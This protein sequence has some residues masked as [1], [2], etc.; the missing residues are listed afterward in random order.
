MPKRSLLSVLIILLAVAFSLQAVYAQETFTVKFNEV[1]STI[2]PNE[3]AV[4]ELNITNNG[5]N[6]EYFT[7][8]SP[9][10]E[11]QLSTEPTSDKNIKLYP[12][13]TYTTIVRLKPVDMPSYGIYGVMVNVRHVRLNK[14]KPTTLLV[15]VRNPLSAVYGTYL[16]ALRVSTVMPKKIDPRKDVKVK[17]NLENRNKLSIEDV[18]V[19]L[20]S[21]L[22]KKD[23]R[24]SLNPLERKTLE[25]TVSFDDLERPRK[26]LLHVT[27]E[28]NIDGRPYEFNAESFEYEIIPYGKIE[29]ET[30]ESSGFLTKEKQIILKNIGNVERKYFYHIKKPFLSW[31]YVSTNPKAT[32]VNIDGSKNFEW[33]FTISPN[34]DEKIIVNYNFWPIVIF[35]LAVAIAL[36]LYFVFRSPVVIRKSAAVTATKDGGMWRIN[37]Q[38]YLKNRSNKEVKHVIVKDKISN[39]L[40]LQQDSE[41]GTLKPYKVLKHDRKGTIASWDVGTL[42]RF[43]ERII[44][45]KTKAK[46]SILG[47]IVLPHAVVSFSRNNRTVQ[48]YSNNVLMRHK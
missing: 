3:T 26:D 14:V 2:L 17:V 25:F 15:T 41:V 40:E 24:T 48:V 1:K 45:Y 42:E 31:M 21:A 33:V 18:N 12:Y 22:I 16:P 35:L 28:V 29:D 5:P 34:M 7:V 47:E 39:L 37:V 6:I 44:T 13:Q 23:Y 38:I 32:V 11:W 30:L 4:F 20:R 19:R 9:D 43:E 27:A 36:I 10:I 46:L 8:Y